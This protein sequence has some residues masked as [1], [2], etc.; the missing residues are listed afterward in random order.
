MEDGVVITPGEVHSASIQTYNDHRVAM[1]F[2]ITG[3]RRQG[4]EI[5]NPMCCKK[6]FPEYFEVLEKLIANGK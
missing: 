4:I 3:L 5:E 2:A 6:T 1:A